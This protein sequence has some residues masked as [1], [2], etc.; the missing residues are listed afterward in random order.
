[1]TRRQAV[2]VEV[3]GLR[4]LVRDLRKLEGDMLDQLKDASRRAGQIIVHYAAPRAPHRSGR[5]AASGRAARLAAG[6]RVLFGR[7][8][9]PYAGPIH[10]G[11]P[12]RNIKAQPFAVDAAHATEPEWLH[13]YAAALDQA[14]A[15]RMEHLYS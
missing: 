3:D 2:S 14:V 11:W 9:V 12:A 13:D 8:S 7:V 5:L 15:H 10:W 4:P 1:M 6:V